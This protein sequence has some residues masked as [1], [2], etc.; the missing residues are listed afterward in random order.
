MGDLDCMKPYSKDKELVYLA[1]RI[2]RWNFVY[3]DKL[4]RDDFE[5]A[6][7]CMEQ[8]GIP[9]TIYSYMSKRLKDNKKLAMLDLQ[10]DYPNTD[11]YSAKLRN[12]DE[13]AERLYELHGTD[14][15]AWYYMSKML[16]KKYGIIE[17]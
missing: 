13:I 9:N 4:F 6:K 8:I 12:D 7:M 16:K 1:C 3:V 15:W 17:K 10:E 11:E 5:L 14:S 2:D